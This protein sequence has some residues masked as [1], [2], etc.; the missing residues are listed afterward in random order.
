MDNAGAAPPRRGRWSCRADRSK[1]QRNARLSAWCRITTT[2]Y[3][4]PILGPGPKLAGPRHRRRAILAAAPKLAAV[5]PKLALPPRRRRRAIP[6]ATRSAPTGRIPSA[7]AG[8]LKFARRSRSRLRSQLALRKQQS[9][10]EQHR[11]AW[12][13]QQQQFSVSWLAPPLRLENVLLF[14][15]FSAGF[16]LI[17]LKSLQQPSAAVGTGL[18]GADLGQLPPAAGASCSGAERANAERNDVAAE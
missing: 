16:D 3:P 13:R 12:R 4:G 11:R 2:R 6:D 9:K 18:A 8:R 1:R 17:L 10:R 14:Q 7:P 5:G 15:W